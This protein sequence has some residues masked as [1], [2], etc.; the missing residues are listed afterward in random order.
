MFFIKIYEKLIPYYLLLKF[1]VRKSY[2]KLIPYYLS[3]KLIKPGMR[4]Q[5]NQTSIT[6]PIGSKIGLDHLEYSPSWITKLIQVF[7]SNK[8]GTFIDI[9]ANTGQTLLD[10]L[11]AGCQKEV[12][13]FGFEPNPKCINFLG[14]FIRVNQLDNCSVVPVGLSDSTTVL[15]L[16]F[17][18]DN[19]IDTAA[20]ILSIKPWRTDKQ[21]IPCYCFDS[22]REII[23]I[24]AISLIKIDV[25]GAELQVLKGMRNS[26]MEYRP[27]VICE[28]LY[29]DHIDDWDDYVQRRVVLMELLFDLGYITFQLQK[30]DNKI[31]E[32]VS[33]NSFPVKRWS[34]ENAAECDYLFVPKEK[35]AEMVVLQKALM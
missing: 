19:S 16:Y 35:A 22:I 29:A 4:I 10:F 24:H 13:Y 14:D 1:I 20:S 15:P 26:L 3:L 23:G 30:I 31:K 17:S 25:E 12:K 2:Y 6:V 32:L 18:S 5:L 9:G 34:Y 27:F 28:V 11:A 8:E 21:F 33:I 7:L